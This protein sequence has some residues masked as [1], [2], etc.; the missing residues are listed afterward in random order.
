M[1]YIKKLCVK[2]VT[3]RK[4]EGFSSYFARINDVTTRI[5]GLL[6]NYIV[7]QLLNRTRT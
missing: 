2:L 1:Y 5:G 4:L 3:Y 7:S 6:D